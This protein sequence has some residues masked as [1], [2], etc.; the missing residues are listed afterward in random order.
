MSGPKKTS[1]DAVPMQV[2]MNILGDRYFEEL[3]TK[4][5]LSYAPAAFFASGVMA[6]PYSV[7]YIST[8]DPK[9]SLEVMVDEINKIKKE[10]FEASELTN[11]KQSFLTYHYMGLETSS[12]QSNSLGMAEVAGSWEM[13]E[14]FTDKV[15]AL[16]LNDLNRVFDVYTKAI[17]WTY[18]GK[19]EQV[20]Q[21]DFVAPVSVPASNKP[22]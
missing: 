17:A 2:A 9:Q 13:A 10:G 16:T 7:I 21:E 1:P 12:S 15:N 11:T 14:S 8:T 22:Y 6:N 4:R 20:K 19:Q 18:L 5:S 3:R